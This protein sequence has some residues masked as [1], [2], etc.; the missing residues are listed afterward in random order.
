[1]QKL[2]ED[3]LK[4]NSLTNLKQVITVNAETAVACGSVSYISHIRYAV[5]KCAKL[6]SIEK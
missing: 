5:C 1:M 2:S 3:L 6:S 4:V